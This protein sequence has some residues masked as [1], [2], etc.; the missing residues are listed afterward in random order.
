MDALPLQQVMSYHPPEAAGSHT[1]QKVISLLARMAVSYSPLHTLAEKRN[2]CTVVYYVC[3][4]FYF[5]LTKA[6]L[7]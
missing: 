6:A 5:S 4:F 3:K 1:G 7:K 2:F